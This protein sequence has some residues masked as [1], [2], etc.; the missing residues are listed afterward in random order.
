M[1][2]KNSTFAPDLG[3][4]SAKQIFNS[5]NEIGDKDKKKEGKKIRR[6]RR[7]LGFLFCDLWRFGCKNEN[8]CR[9][10]QIYLYISKKSI[11][12]APDLGA[13][14]YTRAHMRVKTQK[15]LRKQ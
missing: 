14:R 4:E 12:F 5:P 2:K 10:L 11:T 3:A 9:N 15:R 7:C 6:L 8:I 1:S 13:W